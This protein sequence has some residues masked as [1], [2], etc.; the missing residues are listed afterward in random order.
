MYSFLL[1]LLFHIGVGCTMAAIPPAVLAGFHL[2]VPAPATIQQAF[3]QVFPRVINNLPSFFQQDATVTRTV[4]GQFGLIQLA[5]AFT[6]RPRLAQH[7]AESY[8]TVFETL[9][10]RLMNDAI[11]G[12]NQ[13]YG[14]NLMN[15]NENLTIQVVLVNPAVAGS[16]YASH[17]VRVNAP[18]AVIARRLA[19]HMQ[20]EWNGVL[21]TSPPIH[22]GWNF[23]SNAHGVGPTPRFIIHV[24]L[25]RKPTAARPR[26]NMPTLPAPLAADARLSNTVNL[27]ARPALIFHPRG[28]PYRRADLALTHLGGGLQKAVMNA[29]QVASSLDSFCKSKRSV[30][31]IPDEPDGGC[32]W[33]AAALHINRKNKVVFNQMTKSTKH[34]HRH[35]LNYAQSLCKQIATEAKRDWRTLWILD[36]K[37]IRT[38]TTYLPFQLYLMDGISF[39]MIYKDDDIE[40]INDVAF[41]LVDTARNHVCGLVT[42]LYALAPKKRM[43]KQRTQNRRYCTNC[44]MFYT[45]AYHICSASCSQC[46]LEHKGTV[47]ELEPWIKCPTCDRS[48]KPAC[49]TYHENNPR[50]CKRAWKCLQCMRVF[51]TNSMPRNRHVCEETYCSMCCSVHNNQSPCWLTPLKR[52]EPTRKVV[53]FDFECQL[54]QERVCSDAKDETDIRTVHVPT[55]CMCEY[56]FDDAQGMYARHEQMSIDRPQY[57]RNLQIYSDEKKSFI[58]YMFKTAREFVDFVHQPIHKNYT[59][60]AHNFSGYDGQ[61]ILKACHEARIDVSGLITKGNKIFGFTLPTYSIRFM[62]SFK[63]LSLPLAKLPA[64]LGFPDQS[65]GH[66]PYLF[67]QVDTEQYKGDMPDIEYYLGDHQSTQTQVEIKTWYAEEKKLRSAA[68]ARGERTHEYLMAD[69]V[70]IYCSQDVRI[71]KMAMITYQENM[72]L[73]THVDPLKEYTIASTAM[74]AFRTKFMIPETITVMSGEQ[75]AFVRTG[76]YGGCT[77]VMTPYTNATKCQAYYDDVNSM[78]PS[79]MY[80]HDFPEGNPTW[81]PEVELKIENLPKWNGFVECHVTPPRD[82]L[83]PVLPARVP[84]SDNPSA[85]YKLEFNLYPKTGVWTTIE[86]KYALTLGYTID[87]VTRVL[88]WETMS[89][90]MFRKYIATFTIIKTVAA[91]R[92][93]TI[94]ERLAYFNHLINNHLKLDTRKDREMIDDLIDI[95][96]LQHTR[97]PITELDNDMFKKEFDENDMTLAHWCAYTCSEKNPGQKQTAK[98]LQNSLYGKFGQKTLVEQLRVITD[99]AQLWELLQ[100]EKKQIMDLE[101][102]PDVPVMYAKYLDHAP[103]DYIRP[104]IFANP[105]IAAWTTA[106]GRITLIKR[107]YEVGPENVLYMDTDSVMYTQPLNTPTYPRGNCL[108]EWECELPDGERISHFVSTG[109]KCYSVHTSNDNVFTHLKGWRECVGVNELFEFRSLLNQVFDDSDEPV[110]YTQQLFKCTLGEGVTSIEMDKSFQMVFTKRCTTNIELDPDEKNKVI[111]VP[112]VP[113]GHLLCPHNPGEYQDADEYHRV[114]PDQ[115]FVYDDYNV[116]MK[117]VYRDEEEKEDEHV[118]QRRRL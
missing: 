87:S 76:Y 30:M 18:P 61:F 59:F 89:K 94:E 117:P 11:L 118:H 26:L 68:V 23:L 4:N 42:N 114:Y 66:F 112:T 22:A 33:I 48:Y 73:L 52:K 57:M 40:D 77:E 108:G 90:R 29:I 34:K 71:L 10:A 86:L 45:C 9:L 56:V 101:Q 1:V 43:K 54:R 63:H 97:I 27:N 88:H 85:G 103:R 78:Y 13:Y 47:N 82:I 106:L 84:L 25:Y 20:L 116:W 91:G 102:V 115:Q 3:R 80:F 35:R 8:R 39:N 72:I 46:H 69:E 55:L 96:M 14:N 105:M 31:S 83:M 15:P 113:H 109:P 98:M 81:I 74:K 50:E 92:K 5:Y 107:V 64:T 17:A 100:D 19:R 95:F 38:V 28:V 110:K 79:V 36:V 24:K 51:A 41:M 93:G 2:A 6:V 58:Q 37:D 75:Q 62:D 53:V 99:Q 21:P 70:L 7:P 111:S 67:Y 16:R 49:Y 12:V 65:K 60:I 32:F 104:R 44:D